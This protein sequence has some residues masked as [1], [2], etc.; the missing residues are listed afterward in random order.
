MT[1]NA[2][3]DIQACPIMFTVFDRL[4]SG[5]GHISLLIVSFH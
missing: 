4:Y 2:K 3:D 5:L 1:I